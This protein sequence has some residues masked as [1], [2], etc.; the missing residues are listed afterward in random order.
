MNNAKEGSRSNRLVKCKK[1]GIPHKKEVL[2][3][4]QWRSLSIPERCNKF[5]APHGI[6]VVGYNI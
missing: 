3:K 2:G 4:R 5:D 1:C 6:Q